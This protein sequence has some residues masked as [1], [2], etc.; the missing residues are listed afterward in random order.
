MW[1]SVM[2]FVSTAGNAALDVFTRIYLAI[3][4]AIAALLAVTLVV[5]VVDLL[6]MP[7]RGRGIRGGSSDTVQ[8]SKRETSGTDDAYYDYQDW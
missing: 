2:N 6:I 8:K 4:G 3:P 1:T 7:I 5:L